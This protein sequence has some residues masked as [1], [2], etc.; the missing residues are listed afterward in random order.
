MASK[1]FHFPG[2][3]LVQGDIK[4]DVSL[5]RFEKQF[6]EAQYYLDSQIMNDM[7]P[8]IKTRDGNFVNVTRLQS[9][10]L[11]GSGKVVAAAP[12]MGRFLY[13]G[14]VMVDPVTGS[15]WARKGAKKVVTE[16]PLTYSNPKATPHWFDTAKD[17]HGKAWVKGVKRIAGGGKK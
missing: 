10:A 13:E 15:P 11:A 3:S 7:V 1:T 6:Q 9:A 17:A 2:F 4:V 8:Y 16:R 5:N 14:K 12:P